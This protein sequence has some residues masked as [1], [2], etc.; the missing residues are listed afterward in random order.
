[1]LASRTLN[2]GRRARIARAR[3][4]SSLYLLVPHERPPSPLRDASH[5]PQTLSGYCP[6][7]ACQRYQD[8]YHRTR[9]LRLFISQ[10]D[11]D[12]LLCKKLQSVTLESFRGAQR[13]S[14]FPGSVRQVTRQKRRALQAL[15]NLVV[16]EAALPRGRTYWATPYPGVLRRFPTCLEVYL[17]GTSEL[18]AVT[19]LLYAGPHRLAQPGK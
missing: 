16:G 17:P 19:P 5:A 15:P 10:A 1:L 9:A 6:L 4:Y 3:S 8:L 12:E 13:K 18:Y 2:N 7:M 14:Y 11:K